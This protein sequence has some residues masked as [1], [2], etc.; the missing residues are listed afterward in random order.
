MVL[1]AGL[2]WFCWHGPSSSVTLAAWLV[3]SSI[4]SCRAGTENSPTW[5]GFYEGAVSSGE[6]AAKTVGTLLVQ[7][8]WA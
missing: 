7:E 8:K 3:V 5:P 4:S 2:C 1:F 6:A